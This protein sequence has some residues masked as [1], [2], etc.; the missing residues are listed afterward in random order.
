MAK[1]TGMGST[2]LAWV[3]NTR[4]SEEEPAPG[5]D[6]SPPAEERTP[7]PKAQ[8]A[9]GSKGK[10][11]LETAGNTSE[12]QKSR[13]AEGAKFRSLEAIT[14]RLRGDQLEFLERL[15]RQIMGNRDR[16]SR[17]ERITKNTVVRACLDALREV[18]FDSA[19]IPDET[20]LL[21]RIR[22]GVVGGSSAEVRN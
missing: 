11:Q 7:A 12:L 6:P 2:P 9:R 14:V 10:P 4:E 5:S 17:K 18:G 13:T 1:K 21:R 3:R 8:G 16:D 22:A 19:N 20:E 15:T